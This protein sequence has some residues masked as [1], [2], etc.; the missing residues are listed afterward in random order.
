MYVD[1][2]RQLGRVV[3]VGDEVHRRQV[4]DGLGADLLDHAS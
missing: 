1:V 3:D 2:L 4:D